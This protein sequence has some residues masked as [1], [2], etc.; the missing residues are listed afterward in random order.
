M[1]LREKRHYMRYKDLDQKKKN[2]IKSWNRKGF[3]AAHAL[4]SQGASL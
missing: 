2:E 4:V 1:K 3:M